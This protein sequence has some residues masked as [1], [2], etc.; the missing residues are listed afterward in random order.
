MFWATAAKKNWVHSLWA[1]EQPTAADYLE[2][3]REPFQVNPMLAHTDLGSALFP[4]SSTELV[5]AGEFTRTEM[6]IDSYADLVGA[7]SASI[8][9]NQLEVA[10]GVKRLRAKAK[11]LRESST[12]RKR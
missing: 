10:K 11:K 4:I 6:S 7:S 3:L 1:G 8:R 9:K 12:R 2:Q 5:V